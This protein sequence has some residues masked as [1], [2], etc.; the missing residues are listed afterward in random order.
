MLCIAYNTQSF[1]NHLSLIEFVIEVI[2]QRQKWQ[3]SV[4]LRRL[5]TVTF[6]ASSLTKILVSLLCDQCNALHLISTRLSLTTVLM[7]WILEQS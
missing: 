3:Y 2:A 1:T 7:C 5:F 4:D 6:R